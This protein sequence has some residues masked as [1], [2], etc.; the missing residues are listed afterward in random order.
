MALLVIDVQESLTKVDASNGN[1][2]NAI[3]FPRMIKNTKRLVDAVRFNRDNRDGCGSEVIFTYLEA[4]T[5]DSRDVSLDYKLSG[6]LLSNL[7][8]PSAPA[9]FLPDLTPISGKDICVPKTSC[10]VF[11]STN[12]N[13]I[14]RNLNIEQIV[15]CGQLTDQCV[16]SAVRDAAD[17]GY[18]VSVVEDACGAKTEDC[19][20][21]GLHGMKGFSR[22]VTTDQ[23]LQEIG[24]V[25][26]N[27]KA[28]N[29]ECMRLNQADAVESRS[30]TL[31]IPPSSEYVRNYDRG[32]HSAIIRSLRAAGVKFLRYAVVDVYNS[33]RCK[34]VPISHI[35]SQLPNRTRQTW[36]TVSSSRPL[37]N[38]VSIA[39]G[40]IAGMVS[41]ADKI[42]TSSN[43]SA[44]NVL[45]LRPDFCSLRILP[46]APQTAMVM[47]TVH[48]QQTNKLSPLCTRGLLERVLHVAREDLGIEFCVGAELE[49][50]L[51]RTGPS[52]VPEPVD[53]ST[54]A[55]SLT[56]NEQNKFIDLVYDQLEE[57]DI[58]IE[59]IHCESASSQLEVVIRYCNNPIQLA[60]DIVLA[61]ET[62]SA[63]AKMFGMKALFLPKTSMSDAGNGLH[64][65]FSFKDNN[66]ND[67]FSDRTRQNGISAKGESFIEGILHRL[68]SLLSISMPTVNS[69]RRIGP[70][71]FT[72]HRVEWAFEDKE[73]PIR[74]AANLTTGEATTVEYKLADSSAN[75]Y[76]QLAMI[77]SAGMEGIKSGRILRP[78]SEGDCVASDETNLTIERIPK[79][80]QES[81]NFLKCD[82]FLQAT[83]G[84]ELDTAYVA[85]RQFEIT[86]TE[87]KTLE[88]EVAIAFR[89]A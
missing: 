74:V 48:N 50:M 4:L 78:K 79:S 72:G 21:K 42:V 25:E 57:Q 66:G 37:D 58:A 23:V 51:Y 63:C 24:I 52:G 3:G 39:E 40:C 35:M 29:E 44:R 59:L 64:L 13:Y 1:Y 81:L 73:V 46:Y 67:E 82:D 28:G 34:T 56:L 87:S 45:V 16:E 85:V 5:D 38:A 65:H 15:V 83:M 20:R 76:L 14:L 31:S 10:S 62:I 2:K 26:I 53:I 49:F 27:A 6:P 75:I 88:E 9:K 77:L 54:F 17:L 71:C 11:T 47:C 80:L 43:L 69:F 36:R 30:H 7:P 32:S 33:M 18:F 61:R 70:G 22:R 84:N 12:L 19:H 41:Y 68:P 60:D 86:E 8:N 55:S 89:K